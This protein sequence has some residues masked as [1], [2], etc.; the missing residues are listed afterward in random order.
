[1]GLEEEA[2]GLSEERGLTFQPAE[3]G[4]SE[5]V[6]RE[7]VEREVTECEVT[8]C[9]ASGVRRRDRSRAGSEPATCRPGCLVTGDSIHKVQRQ[10]ADASR[11]VHNGVL[12]V[13]D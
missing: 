2:D 1:M 3:V 7:A 8:E 9:D 10:L 4:E 13:I 12:T 5:A 11:V 6:E